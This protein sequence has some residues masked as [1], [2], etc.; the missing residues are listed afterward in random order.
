MRRRWVR[1]AL[2]LA[3]GLIAVWVLGVRSGETFFGRR[4]ERVKVDPEEARRVRESQTGSDVDVALTGA[5]IPIREELADQPGVLV[6]K[7]GIHIGHSASGGSKRMPAEDVIVDIYNKKPPP[8][9]R[10][11]ARASGDEALIEFQ[12]APDAKAGFRDTVIEGM[13]F[14][15][16]TRVEYL[17]EAGQPATT[18]TSEQLQVT[19][20]R[21]RVPG[22]AVITQEGLKVEGD[23]LSY[24]KATGAFEFEQNVK[25]EGTRFALPETG[26]AEEEPATEEKPAVEGEPPAVETVTTVSCD[27]RFTYLPAE[28][29]SGGAAITG[30]QDAAEALG[31]VKGGL[32]TFRENVTG[33]QD[34]S[35]LLCEELE[36]N[37]ESVKEP[38]GAKPEEKKEDKERLEVTRVIARGA[39]GRPALLKDPQGTLEGETLTMVKTEAGQVVTLLGEPRIHDATFGGPKPTETGAAPEEGAAEAEEGAAA[40]PESRALTFSAGARRQIQLR[41]AAPPP[42]EAP[43]A[44]G[45]EKTRKILLELEDTAF[46]ETKSDTP[47]NDFRI[48]GHRLHLDVLQTEKET[49][50]G[51]AT[52]MR[53]ERLLATGAARGLFSGGVFTG[54]QVEA[55]PRAG[56]TDSSQ[57][58]IH[59][60]PNPDVFLVS[61]LEG[62]TAGERRVRIRSDKGELTYVPAATEEE[63]TQ[64]VFTGPTLLTVEEA[65]QLTTTLNADTRVTVVLD[66]AAGEGG[67]ALSSMVAEGN[68]SFE[69]VPQGVT[70]TGERLTLVPTEAGR[71]RF[72]LSGSAERP[73]VA[74]SAAEGE[75]SRDVAALDIDFDPDSGRLNAKGRVEARGTGLSLG[76]DMGPALAEAQVTADPSVLKCEDLQVFSDESGG[77]V[78]EARTDVR[79]EDPARRLSATADQLFYEETAGKARLLGREYEPAFVTR[80]A[81]PGS[82]GRPPRTVSIGGPEVL[83]D[84]A[85]NTLTCERNGVVRLVRPEFE[86]AKEQR[87][88]GRSAGPVRYFQ[89]RLVLQQDVVVGFAEDGVETR[90]LWCDL[91]TVLFSEQ[92][93]EA[94]AEESAA[95][96]ETAGAEAAGAVAAPGSAREDSGFDRLVAEGR[97][98]FEET[99]PREMIAEGQRLEWIMNEA[100]EVLI[101]SGTNP[102]CWIVGLLGDKDFRDEADWFRLHRISNEVQAEN[103]RTV[104]IQEVSRR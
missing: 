78:V 81:A 87:V 43:Q 98:H 9:E 62:E 36:I 85:S 53:L 84:Q 104:F 61:K 1:F 95:E 56:S 47:E 26:A 66:T 77:S 54:D 58:E 76:E 6:L 25:V 11:V 68:V 79:F 74:H 90:A 23:V 8:D 64:A 19:E 39:P 35:T 5:M 2:L 71:Y 29:E 93:P 89:D 97:I 88:D 67:D 20:E 42:G 49:P 12:S 13:T 69:N 60:S 72:R 46:L 101:L 38:E 31:K 37:I 83:L 52:D 16:N 48:E 86:G 70:G 41:P 55:F 50:E 102:Q 28:D 103:G 51:T 33:R 7:Y 96:G 40:P 21:F 91:A 57:F 73:A 15:K 65:G 34:Q 45:A 17:D 10:I 44:K 32:L 100:D 99:A 59:V 14:L 24:E 18:M 75:A 63:K 82:D 27:G 94:P 30:K 22:H 80:G 4:Q 3:V 92:E